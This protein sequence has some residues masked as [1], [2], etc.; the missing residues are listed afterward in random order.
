[1]AMILGFSIKEVNTTR[2]SDLIKLAGVKLIDR[3]LIEVRISH[4][5]SMCFAYF[6]F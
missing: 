5:K 1:M 2:E 6:L 4:R 3:F